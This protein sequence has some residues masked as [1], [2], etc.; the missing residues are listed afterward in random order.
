MKGNRLR[1]K[2]K[3]GIFREILKVGIL[4]EINGSNSGNLQLSGRFHNFQSL[5]FPVID[6][7]D[8]DGAPILFV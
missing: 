6:S 3:V 5:V 7:K 2:M 1:K 8:K 4:R